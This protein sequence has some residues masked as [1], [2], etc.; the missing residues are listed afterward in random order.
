MHHL[1]CRC[2]AGIF[3]AMRTVP[4]TNIVD[5]ADLGIKRTA[6]QISPEF[7]KRKHFMPLYRYYLM[8]CDEAIR[9]NIIQHSEYRSLTKRYA[10]LALENLV[11]IMEQL[12]MRRIQNIRHVNWHKEGNIIS[13]AD[14]L[15]D[16]VIAHG[17]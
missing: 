3:N 14:S 4:N 9:C 5:L 2:Y 11:S 12:I 15:L 10:H 16:N 6:T 13:N 7:L 8:L 17:N 1:L